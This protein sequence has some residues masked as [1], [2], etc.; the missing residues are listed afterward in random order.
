MPK[1]PDPAQPRPLDLIERRPLFRGHLK[2]DAFRLRHGLFAGGM[3]PEFTREIVYRRDAVTVLPYDPVRDAVVLIEQFRAST[4]IHGDPAWM[5]EVVAG[6]IE[7]GELPEEVGVRELAE[8]AGLA[9][10]GPLLPITMMYSTPGF[11]S[12]RFY[13]FCA[14]VDS[15]RAGGVHGLPEEI[16]DIRVFALPFGEAF[17][18]W[19]AGR[20]PNSPAASSLLWLALHRDKLQKNWADPRGLPVR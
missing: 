7:D 8:E 4:L 1:P 5:I 11:C 16:E 14:P 2:I 19:E 3:T 17:A 18:L 9:P 6:L 15:S 12:E 13:M 10:T 20:I